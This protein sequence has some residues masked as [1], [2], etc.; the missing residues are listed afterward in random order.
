MGLPIYEA[1]PLAQSLVKRIKPV[2]RRVEVAGSIRRRKETVK[3]VELVI[4]CDDYEGLFK[5]LGPAGRFIKPGVP[6]VVD[7]SPKPNAKYLRMLLNEGIKLDIFVA[8]RDNWG[9]IYTMRTGSGVD[10]HGNVF[11]GFVPRMFARWK[12]ISGGGRMMGGQPCRPDGT[13]LAVPEEE[14]FFD[15][16]QARWVPPENRIDGNAIHALKEK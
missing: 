1:L 14:D 6:N 12:R 10:A 7:W 8:H 4:I 13:I 5:R 15:L 9:G 16:C 11:N 2:T 3:D